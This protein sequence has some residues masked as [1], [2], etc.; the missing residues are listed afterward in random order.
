MANANVSVAVEPYF[1]LSESKPDEGRFV[2]AYTVTIKN[3]GQSHAKLLTRHWV[4]TNG[5]TL[6]TTEV[7]GDGVIG[8]QPT[9]QP[10]E[11][12]I[13]TSGTIMESAVGTMQGSYRMIDAEGEYFD[14]SI[15]VFTLAATNSLH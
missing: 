8:E 3:N 9:I 11:E 4:I 5:E 13:Y 10:G 14:I 6:A 1:L 12:Y 15:P 2:Y 7:K